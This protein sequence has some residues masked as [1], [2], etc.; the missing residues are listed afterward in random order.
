[1]T[2]SERPPGN[3]RARKTG[4]GAAKPIRTSW[5]RPTLRGTVFGIVGVLGVLIAYGIGRTE[6]LYAAG[7]LI[8]LPLV[9]LVVVRF[10]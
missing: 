6:V 3:Q 9:G 7:F 2:R 8:L 1:M 10:G 5:S 4:R